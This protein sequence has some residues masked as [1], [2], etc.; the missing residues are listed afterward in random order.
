MDDLCQR[1]KLSMCDP[2]LGLVRDD[3]VMCCLE[4]GYAGCSVWRLGCCLQPG[5][6][7]PNDCQHALPCWQWR[8]AIMAA[9]QQWPLQLASCRHL[10][11]Q[12]AQLQLYYGDLSI[13]NDAKKVF[14]DGRHTKLQQARQSQRLVRLL[15]TTRHMKLS[16]EPLER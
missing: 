10:P 9:K 2:G 3:D 7:L 12:T 15:Q 5:P 13:S 8:N 6:D 14:G 16:Q 1:G 11:W 4:S